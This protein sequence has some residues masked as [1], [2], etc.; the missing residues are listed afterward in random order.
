MLKGYS[1]IRKQSPNNRTGVRKMAEKLNQNKDSND[2]LNDESSKRS[3][4][5]STEKSGETPV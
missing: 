5:L 4:Y 3:P 2:Y 1:N